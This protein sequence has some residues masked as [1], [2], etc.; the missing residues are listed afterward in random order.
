MNDQVLSEWDRQHEGGGEGF[1]KLYGQKEVRSE[2]N[3]EGQEG[4]GKESLGMTSSWRGRH[5][6]R[7][8]NEQGRLTVSGQT[9]WSTSCVG[10]SGQDG[11]VGPVYAGYMSLTRRM[12]GTSEELETPCH[13]IKYCFRKIFR[14]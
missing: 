5:I 4:F 12:R 8:K 3:L 13:I 1:Y 14:Q 6:F 7:G 11:W 10:S 9:V 2:M